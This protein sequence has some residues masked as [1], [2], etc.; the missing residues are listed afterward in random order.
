MRRYSSC[1]IHTTDS[2]DRHE[3][4]MAIS[5]ATG[6]T[7]VHLRSGDHA[8]SGTSS[9]HSATCPGRY[10][11]YIELTRIQDEGKKHIYVYTKF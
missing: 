11:R 10:V 5:F 7:R 6:S 8:L 4:Y 9:S 3:V 1:S 2:D